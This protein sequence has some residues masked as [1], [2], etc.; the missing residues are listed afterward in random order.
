V[1]RAPGWVGFAQTSF[2]LAKSRF[3]LDEIDQVLGEAKIFIGIGTSGH[4]YPSAGFVERARSNGAWCIEINKDQTALST[5]FDDQRLGPAS[6]E[7]P[8]LITE[9]LS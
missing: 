9:L 8:N 4:V 1:I 7:M 6:V 5:R 3:N 2:G